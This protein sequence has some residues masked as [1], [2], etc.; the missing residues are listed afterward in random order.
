MKTIPIALTLWLLAPLAG[1]D[2]D[3]NGIP[4]RVAALEEITY[5]QQLDIDALMAQGGGGTGWVVTALLPGQP[6]G[7]ERQVIGQVMSFVFPDTVVVE[8]DI[9]DHPVLLWIGFPDHINL[10][11][12]LVFTSGDCS[13]GADEQQYA[14]P[15][16]GWWYQEVF[17]APGPDANGNSA[18]PYLPDGGMPPTEGP[19]QSRWE[20]DGCHQFEVSPGVPGPVPIP[21]VPVSRLADDLYMLY[22][23]APE[24]WMLAHE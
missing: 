8:T 16:G 5:Q 15:P 22:P 3:S 2:E 18:V 14:L 10:P 17:M 9:A 23:R 4:F 13:L 11:S 1:A 12:R 20:P 21:A 19:W 6:S 24:P 7:G